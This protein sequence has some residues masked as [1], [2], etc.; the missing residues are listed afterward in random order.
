MKKTHLYFLLI[1][2]VALALLTAGVSY[3]WFAQHASM[4]T[5]LNILPPDTIT[6]I[7]VDR[8]DKDLV[9]DEL[10]LEFHEDTG[11]KYPDKDEDGKIT[12]YRPV[13]IKSTNPSHKLE[14]VHT[15][16]LNDLTF[17]IYLAET[18]SDKSIQFSEDSQKEGDDKRIPLAGGYINQKNGSSKL[19]DPNNLENYKNGDTVEAHAYPLYWLPTYFS[20]YVSSD[21]TLPPEGAI[22]VR[23]DTKKEFDSVSGTDKTFY[24]TYYYLEISWKE[25]TKQTDLFY[26]MAY[27]IA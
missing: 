18:S 27:N 23:S 8:N 3:A 10:E 16:N 20:S 15:T 6:I 17:K 13:C 24:Y 4:A 12:I 9:L 1:S 14:I 26:I 2:A 21:D 22:G 11:A 7:P 5:L 19:A 25:E